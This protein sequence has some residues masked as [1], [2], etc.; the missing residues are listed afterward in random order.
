MLKKTLIALAVAA[1]TAPAMAAIDVATTGNGELFLAVSNWT[2]ASEASRV[3]YTFDTGIKMDDFLPGSAAA[4]TGSTTALT[5]WS[6]FLSTLATA[7]GSTAD[8]RFSL[9]ALD[10]TLTGTYNAT[11]AGARRVLTTSTLNAAGVTEPGDGVGE[12]L[13]NIDLT[14]I[15][16]LSSKV[17]QFLN[18]TNGLASHSSTANGWSVNVRNGAIDAADFGNAFLDSLGSEGSDFN[19]T[20]GAALNSSI[21]FLYAANGSL[22]GGTYGGKV[23]NV[24]DY[25]EASFS[26]LD[27]GTLVYSVAAIPEP[28]ELAFM[29]SGLALAGMV[30]RR[31]AARRA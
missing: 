23:A 2:A 28:G 6:T 12:S 14:N 25:A 3:T 18:A 5:G 27:N 26:V 17:S 7:G 22:S 16:A 9:F 1:A 4:T 20:T 8:L 13:Q 29:L 15:T 11:N 30:A 31:R 19:F 21:G 24:I 10:S